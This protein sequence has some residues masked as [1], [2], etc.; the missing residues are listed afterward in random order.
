MVPM[1]TMY[2]N[3]RVPKYQ[4]VLMLTK[5]PNANYQGTNCQGTPDGAYADHV[6][7]YPSTKVPGR[8]Y[9]DQVPKVLK[10]QDMLMLTKYPRCEILL[11]LPWP[12]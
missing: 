11:R 1:L 2:P 9:I 10:Y 7:K 5:Y 12:Q 3:T 4:D 8:A 6:P